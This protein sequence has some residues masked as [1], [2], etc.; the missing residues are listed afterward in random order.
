MRGRIIRN[1]FLTAKRSKDFGEP[2]MSDRHFNHRHKSCTR[3]WQPGQASFEGLRVRRA[4]GYPPHWQ[5]SD[6][7]SSIRLWAFSPRP[8]K[9]CSMKIVVIGGSGLIGKKLVN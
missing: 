2:S 4:V 8:Q 1:R 7:E 9:A 5:A 6:H 3:H